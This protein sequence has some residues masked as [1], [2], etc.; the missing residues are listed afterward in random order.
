M[1]PKYLF[2]GWICLC[3]EQNRL[4]QADLWARIQDV[5][6]YFWKMQIFSW[7]FYFFMI[8]LHCSPLPVPFF[9][10]S[11][12]SKSWW[13]FIANDDCEKT[14]GIWI[15]STSKIHPFSFYLSQKIFL[16]FLLQYFRLHWWTICTKCQWELINPHQLWHLY[17][18]FLFQEVWPMIAAICTPYWSI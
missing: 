5:L 10:D 11:W 1:K 12:R 16:M 9:Q 3:L 2:W 14:Q 4:H 13:I 7:I 15:F 18:L 8:T 6:F 17:N